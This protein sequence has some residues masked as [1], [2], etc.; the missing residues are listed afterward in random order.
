MLAVVSQAR[1]TSMRLPGKSLRVL[2]AG[3]SVLQLHVERLQ[4]CERPDLVVVTTSTDASDDP[5]AE[6]CER[7]GVEVHRGPLEDVARRFYDVVERFGLDAFVRVTGDSPLLDQGLV[8]EGIDVFREGGHE[9]VSNIR[10]S[11]YASGQSWE[12]VDAVAFRA[13]YPDM[14]EPEHFEHVTNFLYSH[15]ERFHFRNV[16][17]E[18]DEGA[19]NL[20]VDTEEDAALVEAILARME[21]PHWE[22][23]YDDV[24]RLYREVTA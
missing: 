10:P 4:H 19:I 9:I 21:R 22:Y 7:L 5:I 20:S 18:P 13:A 16:R 8:D 24:M 2:H 23:R 15:P 12:A 1:M 17:K 11:T 14:S 6:L 3:R